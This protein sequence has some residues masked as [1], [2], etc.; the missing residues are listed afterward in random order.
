VWPDANGKACGWAASLIISANATVYRIWRSS[1][2][3]INP[4]DPC[5]ISWSSLYQEPELVT[6]I[7]QVWKNDGLPADIPSFIHRIESLFV[8]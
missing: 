7:M 3:S 6:H 5:R 1:P 4:Y 2:T 8:H